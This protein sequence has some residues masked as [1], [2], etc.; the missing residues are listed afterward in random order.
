MALGPVPPYGP[1]TTW[2]GKENDYFSSLFSC[3]RRLLG[4]GGIKHSGCLRVRL[5]VCESVRASVSPIFTLLFP[6][7]METF[8]RN[9]SQLV[10]TRSTSPRE[11]HWV[12]G[13]GQP[14]M[15]I[16]ML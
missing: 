14:M 13:Q 11:G 12:K 2:L 6:E 7:R 16:E 8:Q 9:R 1:G 4:T 10:T 3:L 15:A 5:F